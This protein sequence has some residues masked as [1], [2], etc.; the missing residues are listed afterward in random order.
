MNKQKIKILAG[1]AIIIFSLSLNSLQAQKTKYLAVNTS[2]SKV[3]WTG[4]K[5]GGEHTGYV[6]LSEGEIVVQKNEVVGGSFIIDLNTI[7]N[8]DLKNEGMNS[9]LV[10]HLK[11]PDFF[12]VAQYPVARFD[13]TKVSRISGAKEGE[14]KATH[15][16]E[17]NLTMKG[18][19]KKVEFN[20]SINLLNGK[21]VANTEQFIINRTLWGVNYESKSIF[22]ELK[23]KFIKDDIGLSIEL[24]TK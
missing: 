17:G 1:S 16:I 19:T 8:V 23:D 6:K 15:R 2:E 10:G 21:L 12:D 3:N 13:M 22:A 14:A 4:N 5:P 20:A 11:S 24:V 7:I 9:R 18:I